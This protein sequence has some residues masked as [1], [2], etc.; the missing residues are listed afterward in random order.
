VYLR[1]AQI[2]SETAW[3]ALNKEGEDGTWRA[4]DLNG[5]WGFR[6]GGE[7]GVGAVG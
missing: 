2:R 3:M 1:F 6:F 5:G 7:E 4:W